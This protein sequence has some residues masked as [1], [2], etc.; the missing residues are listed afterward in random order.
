MI[1][2]EQ[3]R[4]C[5]AHELQ[6]A[7]NC[8]FTS[9]IGVVDTSGRDRPDLLRCFQVWTACWQA[10]MAGFADGVPRP[11]KPTDFLF[12][13]R[14]QAFDMGKHKGIGWN[15]RRVRHGQRLRRAVI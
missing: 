5:L 7:I 4:L 1:Y 13:A 10:R 8:P 6:A 9:H 12:C 14:A 3:A 11:S 15:G 2:E